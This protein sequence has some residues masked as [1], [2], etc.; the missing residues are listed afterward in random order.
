MKRKLGVSLLF[1]AVIAL[2]FTGCFEQS[3]NSPVSAPSTPQAAMRAVES[4]GVYTM[5]N[6]IDQNR[7]LAFRRNADGTLTSLGAFD[8]GGQGTGGTIDPLK[9]QYSI[10][11]NEDHSMLFA[12][13]AGS[14]EVSVFEVNPD[15][16]LTLL[17]HISSGGSM[18]VS[19]AV[20][21]RYLYV[22]NAGDNTI[23]GFRMNPK[24]LHAIAQSTH[25]LAS[26]AA[27]AST[28]EFTPDGEWL[29]VTERNANRLETF[30]VLNNG[31]TGDP[32]VSPSSGAVPFGFDITPEGMPVVSEAG[33]APP[34]GAVSSYELKRDGTLSPISR[35]VDSGGAAACWLI[36]TP[37][38]EIGFV[39]NAGANA[40]ASFDVAQGAVTLLNATAGLTS[41]GATPLDPDVVGDR[42]LYVLEGGSGNIASF[43]IGGGGALTLQGETPAG[44]ASGGLQGMAAW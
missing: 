7:I 3:P 6:G 35:S 19:L 17:Q 18:P 24:G 13:D 28:I 38:G 8:T 12:V 15:A 14:N 10:V 11:L 26:G 36:L 34:D 31:R 1:A 23:S 41:A 27:G 39:V 16:S 9:S 30:H 44:Q 20:W 43:Q 2:S 33:G 21:D 29:V 4:G 40:I 42:F 25:S 32:T 37:G 22:L 5:T